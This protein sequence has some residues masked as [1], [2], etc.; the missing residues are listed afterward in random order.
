MGN[1][2]TALVIVDVQKGFIN[3][4]TSHVVPLVESAQEDSLYSLICATQFV[5]SP[6][7]PYVRWMSWARFQ[8]ENAYDID[9]AFNLKKD[10]HTFQKQ[11][12]YAPS[13]LFDV[14]DEKEIR[15]VHICGID[16]NMCVF[17]TAIQLFD[18][19]VFEPFVLTNL[20]ASHS[21]EHYHKE[22]VKML[23]KAIGNN[24]LIR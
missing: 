23:E 17:A 11:T 9:L 21:G 1:L 19:G 5:N 12:Y 16:T 22:G 24:H 10:A 20:C 18:G 13:E 6:S 7:S 14:F 15:K 4:H 2:P 8:P 3:E